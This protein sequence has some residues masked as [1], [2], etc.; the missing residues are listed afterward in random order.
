MDTEK[1][2]ESK[3]EREREGITEITLTNELIRLGITQEED[4]FT[5]V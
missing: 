1:G 3:K 2:G 5:C 4:T